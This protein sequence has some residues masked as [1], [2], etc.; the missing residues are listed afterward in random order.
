MYKQTFGL[1]MSIT[2]FFR[3]MLAVTVGVFL[4]ACTSKLDEDVYA[5]YAD[6]VFDGHDFLTDR[7]VVVEHG[8]ITRIVDSEDI[9][10]L[11]I[12]VIEL[13]DATLLPG[14]IDLHTHILYQHVPNKTILEHGVTTVRDLGGPLHQHEGNLRILTSGLI[15]TAP[16]GYPINKMGEKD[17]A[18]PISSEQHAR[19]VVRQ[20]VSSGASIIKVALEAGGEDGAPWASN[21]HHKHET[22][23]HN[24][25]QQW[26]MLPLTVVEAIVDE[27]HKL[28]RKV[29]AHVGEERGAQLSLEAG[30]DE[31]AH[32]PCDFI[33]IQVLE[34]AV[35]QQVAMVTTLDTLSKCSGIEHNTK[36][37]ASLGANFLY[38]AEIAHPDI[39]WGIDAQELMLMASFTKMSE[40]DVLRT[41]T[42]KAGAYL[43]MPELGVIKE[44][45]VADMIAVKGDALQSLKLLE[46]P[47]LV[48]ANG[49]II[50]NK[51][52]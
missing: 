50:I 4:S 11:G 17:L 8:R 36:V 29:T 34:R 21:N 38:G 25:Y 12:D 49:A 46:F 5:V 13:D 48:I 42:S 7:A 41:A 51:F 22:H 3:I 10:M 19:E 23:D 39:P 30:V 20:Q 44:G 45:A 52:M 32:I 24:S 27:A 26:P 9:H 1:S 28:N 37:L 40:T 18:I 2:I 47:D 16:H 14:F 33:S 35:Q 31:W 43:A 15:L 6:R